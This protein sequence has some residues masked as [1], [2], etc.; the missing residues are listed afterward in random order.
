VTVEALVIVGIVV[1]YHH[2]LSKTMHVDTRR[3]EAK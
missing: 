3:K 1:L 2:E